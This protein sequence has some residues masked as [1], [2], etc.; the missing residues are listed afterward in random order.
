MPIAEAIEVNLSSVAEVTSWKHAFKAGRPFIDDLSDLKD[1]FDFAVLVITPDDILMSRQ[2]NFLAPRDNI[3]FEFGLFIGSIGKERV[4]AISDENL[5]PKIFSDYLG[6]TYLTYDS[7]RKDKDMN[8]ALS[9][10]CIKIKDRI[11][12]LGQKKRVPIESIDLQFPENTL[13][14]L[15]KIYS[16]YDHAEKDL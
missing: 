12:E 13:I 5:N 9:P 10:P 3:I 15:E 2:Q 16:T 14:G 8:R 4:Y 7:N 1:K 11:K 6:V